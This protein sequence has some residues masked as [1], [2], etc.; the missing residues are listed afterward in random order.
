M[1]QLDLSGISKLGG[2]LLANEGPL[3]VR[4][5]VTEYAH[6]AALVSGR[7]AYPG[8]VVY[9]NSTDNKKGLYICE[10]K[11]NGGSW[12]ILPKMSI[13]EGSP[14]DLNNNFPNAIE[15]DIVIV[16]SSN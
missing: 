16:V 6:L 13:H 9:V 8:M 12:R 10:S 7:I 2:Y 1:A 15:G 5:V 11:E 14:N 3:D 4:T